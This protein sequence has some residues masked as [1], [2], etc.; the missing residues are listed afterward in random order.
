MRRAVLALAL[1]GVAWSAPARGDDTQPSPERIK[2]AAEEFDRGRRAYLSRD[3]DEA[4]VH[5]ENAFRDA[6]RAETLRLAIRARRDAKQL[7]RAATL[8]AIA[9][10]RYPDDAPTGQLTDE[11][12]EAAAPE[13]HELVIDCSGECAVAADGRVVS[14]SDALRH[15][16]FLEPGSHEIGVSFAGGRSV[17]RRIEAS[18]GGRDTLA[19]A[20][21]V[22]E[23][24]PVTE[25]APPAAPPTTPAAAP[26][27][28]G[29]AEPPEIARGGE[30]PFGPVVFFVVAGAT[31]IAGG[32]TV[33]SGLDAEASPGQETVRRECAGKDGSCP[34][35]DAGQAKEV[36]TNVLLGATIG[37]AVAAGVIGV[38][39]TKWSPARE[40]ARSALRLG[41][42]GISAA[43]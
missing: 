24:T 9:R 2:A 10:E 35:Y 13:L 25:P 20:P 31:A 14:Q 18:I 41:L 43:W 28:T 22:A 3:F 38:F 36:R 1:I 7:A 4:A 30:E 19:F 23:P 40:P 15:R 16:I 21:P 27:P 17:V 39:F 42:G 37:L 12:L 8:A 32:A 34:A 5:F 33:W 29:G 6:P 11:T 26:R